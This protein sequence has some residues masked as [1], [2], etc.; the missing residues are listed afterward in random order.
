MKRSLLSPLGALAALLV[1]SA[2]FAAPSLKDSNGEALSGVADVSRQAH[3][4]IQCTL[5]V[6]TTATLLSA[7]WA[8][9]G[10]SGFDAT[11]QFAFVQPVTGQI[12]YRTDGTAPTFTTGPNGTG[13]LIGQQQAWPIEGPLSLIALSL[14]SGVS[15]Q[16]VTT[17]VEL[18]H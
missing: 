9:A 6:T 8:T 1:S 2:V 4:H 14:I 12:Y 7:L 3:A 13:M 16:S 17:N 18:R 5:T 15:G 10:C 11:A